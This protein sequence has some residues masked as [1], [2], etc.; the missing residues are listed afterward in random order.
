[1]TINKCEIEAE[2]YPGR[3]PLKKIE[4]EAYTSEYISPEEIARALYKLEY[5]AF[6]ERRKTGNDT[7]GKED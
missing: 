2:L 1:M 5:E 7:C 3:D 4:I 6:L